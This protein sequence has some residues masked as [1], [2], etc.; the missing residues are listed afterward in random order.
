MFFEIGYAKA[1]GKELIF[2]LQRGFDHEFFDVAHIRRIDYDL[3]NPVEM[4]SKLA[5]TIKNIRGKR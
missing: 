1:L 4:Q 3:D 2:L 5:D